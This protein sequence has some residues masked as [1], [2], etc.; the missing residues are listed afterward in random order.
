MDELIPVITVK[1][2][3]AKVNMNQEEFGKSIGVSAQT[4]GSWEKDILKISPDNL[5]KLCLKYKIK[6][7]DLL[8]V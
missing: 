5:V 7:S 6:S 1:E 2:L 3:R 8:G 4:V